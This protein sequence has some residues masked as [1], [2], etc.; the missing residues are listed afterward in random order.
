MVRLYRLRLIDALATNICPGRGGLNIG[1]TSA[2]P[3]KLA[4][5]GTPDGV[6]YP[7]ETGTAGT[8]GGGVGICPMGAGALALT[9]GEGSALFPTCVALRVAG[10]PASN[11]L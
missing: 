8:D 1:R 2:A 6:G 10:T 4:T 9:D 3:A 11:G 5:F 7:D